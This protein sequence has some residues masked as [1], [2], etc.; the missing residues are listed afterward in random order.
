MTVHT[1]ADIAG[2]GAAVRLVATPGLRA[3]WILFCSETGISNVGDA[4]VAAARG[5][6]C[7]AAVPVLFPQNGADQT[8][9]YDLYNTWA[10]VPNGSTL[11]ITYGV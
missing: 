2:S 4:N 8:D 5:V 11:T 6:D 3:R 1:I 7:P 9:A 10:W